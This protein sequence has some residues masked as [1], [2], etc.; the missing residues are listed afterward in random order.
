[1]SN[2]D[3]T[4]MLELHGLK[5]P[6]RQKFLFSALLDSCDRTHSALMFAA[7]ISAAHFFRA[8]AVRRRRAGARRRY[9]PTIDA[10]VLAAHELVRERFVA[11]K[12]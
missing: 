6:N 9:T 8:A 3:A 10:D 4:A 5:E 2:I 11:A 1:M 7:L 12:H